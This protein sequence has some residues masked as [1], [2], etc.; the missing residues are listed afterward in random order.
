MNLFKK[1]KLNTCFFSRFVLSWNQRISCSCSLMISGICVNFSYSF[2]L[3]ISMSSSTFTTRGSPSLWRSKNGSVYTS[4]VW[5]LPLLPLFKEISYLVTFS[6]FAAVFFS[7][8]L[9]ILS[10]VFVALRFLSSSYD[11]SKS[12][13]SLRRL[14]DLPWPILTNLIPSCIRASSNSRVLGTF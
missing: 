7:I 3:S 4:L 2:T 14:I 6:L 11:I 13:S 10:Y 8:A 9:N 1:S 12:P 5:Y